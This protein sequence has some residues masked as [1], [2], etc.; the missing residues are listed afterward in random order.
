MEVD[1]Y[2]ILS[3]AS[4]FIQRAFSSAFSSVRSPGSSV[5]AQLRSVSQ[6]GAA[7]SGR[8][9]VPTTPPS[10]SRFR[11]VMLGV[12]RRESG[13]RGEFA[14]DTVNKAN[15]AFRSGDTKG[16][17][18]LLATGI[19][20]L[21]PA[22]VAA[23]GDDTRP[24]TSPTLAAQSLAASSSKAV[25][26]SEERT[27]VST[28]LP[29]AMHAGWRANLGRGVAALIARAEGLLPRVEI[30]ADAGI[31][32]GDTSR[33]ALLDAIRRD[34]SITASYR[35]AITNAAALNNGGRHDEALAVLRADPKHQDI[36]AYFAAPDGA[37]GSGQAFFDLSVWDSELN[38][39]QTLVSGD[40]DA[41]S[42]A[43][44]AYVS[45]AR[46][47]PDVLQT[48]GLVQ[49]VGAE[50]FRIGAYRAVLDTVLPPE[51]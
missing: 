9:A 32:N 14:R 18:T 37:F 11:D 28:F 30:D 1:V 38:R 5:G 49:S 51:A 33:D 27:P 23:G 15:A 17:R 47:H 34:G 39:F 43:F 13:P 16:A 26:T 44:G 10:Y 21:C 12:A 3:S 29:E 41:P 2:P 22:R 24:A 19:A 4:G 20:T 35:Q 48:R 42:G 50:L 25:S 6:A 40:G 45:Y 7:A 46:E 8:P 31:V 36:M